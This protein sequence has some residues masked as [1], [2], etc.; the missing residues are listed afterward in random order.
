VALYVTVGV[1]FGL[2]RAFYFILSS[3]LRLSE[4]I[5]VIAAHCVSTPIFET[6][7]SSGPYKLHCSCSRH[8]TVPV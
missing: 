8:C 5:V 1:Y 2:G 4:S 7:I 6:V 3:I